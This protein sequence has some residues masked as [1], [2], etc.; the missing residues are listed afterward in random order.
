MASFIPVHHQ[1]TL[2]QYNDMRPKRKVPI[3]AARI[4][5][6]KALMDAGDH[7]GAAQRMREVREL[8]EEYEKRIK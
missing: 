4:R 1:F 8:L 7:K 3:S 6:A 5:E 2:F